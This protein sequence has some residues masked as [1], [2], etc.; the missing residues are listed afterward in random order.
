MQGAASGAVQQLQCTPLHSLLQCGDT[1]LI[2]IH[3]T[4]A[5]SGLYSQHNYFLLHNAFH[6]AV[7]ISNSG[8]GRLELTN[9]TYNLWEKRLCPTI[10]Y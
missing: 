8:P 4:T 6:V 7:I 10:R 2:I 1:L 5:S 3:T 9:E